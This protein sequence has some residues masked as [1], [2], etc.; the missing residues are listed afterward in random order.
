MKKG[1]EP[2]KEGPEHD[3]LEDEVNTLSVLSPTSRFPFHFL[4]SLECEFVCI[5][6]PRSYVLPDEIRKRSS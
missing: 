3:D 4:F 5:D 2:S 1:Y 6:S